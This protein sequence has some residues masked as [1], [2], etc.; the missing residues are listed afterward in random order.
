MNHFQSWKNLVQTYSSCQLTFQKDRL[1]ALSGTAKKMMQSGAQTYMAGLWKENLADGLVW[2]R[3]GSTDALLAISGSR[4]VEYLGP[5]FSWAAVAGEVTWR[6]RGEEQTIKIL[7]VR[8]QPSTLDICG[9]VK[10]GY[11]KV[12]GRLAPCK[13]INK[14][15]QGTS[16]LQQLDIGGFPHLDAMEDAEYSSEVN[17]YCLEIFTSKSKKPL[18]DPYKTMWSTALL[19]T[20]Q[21]I[22]GSY[23]EKACQRARANS[24]QAELDDL[25]RVPWYTRIGA[26]HL[27]DPAV[28]ENRP[29]SDIL[30]L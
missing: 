4:P 30:I 24:T 2:H 6:A 7:D 26:V 10:C 20:A 3:T 9:Q 29:E 15:L 23:A 17:A 16:Q 18:S 14:P 27:L 11:V 19:L 21:T 13:I 1:P 5:T 28:F 8:C 25:V 22:S 12:R